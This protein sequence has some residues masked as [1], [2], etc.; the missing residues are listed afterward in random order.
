MTKIKSSRT[1]LT[2]PRHGLT[3][4]TRAVFVA[5]LGLWGLASGPG[6]QATQSIVQ[7]FFVPFP[8]TDFKASLQA[9]ATGTTVTTNIQTVVSIVVG[10]TNTVIVYD[11]WE[12]GYENDLANP[13]KASTQIWGDGNTNNGTAPGY[14]N[15]ILPLGAV[16]TLTNVVTLPRNPS[17]VKYDGRDRIGATRAVTVTRAGWETNI[18]TLLASAT[19]VYDTSRYGT[20]FI[21]P[22]GTNTTPAIENFSYSSLH[23]IA[24]ENGTVVMVDRNGDGIMDVTNTLN[25]GESMFVNGGVVAGATVTASK[26]VQVHQLTGRIG[27]N[28]QSRTFAIRPVS[29]WD[30]SYYAP[31]GTTTATYA[32]NVFVFNQYLTNITVLYSTRTTNSSFS[33][34]TNSSL[35]VPHAAQFGRPLLYDQW[36][37]LLCGGR[38]RHRQFDPRQ[39]PEL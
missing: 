12:D 33:V 25:M 37:R 28:Y 32:H 6:V 34:P 21:I 19:E 22:V 16:I 5:A 18:G 14:P 26:P 29:Q 4:L 39:Q 13:V 27:S 38:Q 15:D 7:Q 31:V 24:A 11:H 10:A 8:E 2:T 3:R 23:I 20:Y 35:Q 17:T 9:I 1:V 30:T 36:G